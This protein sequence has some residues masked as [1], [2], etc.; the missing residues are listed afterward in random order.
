MDSKF[1]SSFIPK[2]SYG[3]AGDEKQEFNFFSVV[4]I[5]LFILSIFVTGGLFFYRMSLKSDNENLK[6]Q[7]ST[8]AAAIDI[9][10]IN[11][12]MAFEK[13]I[14]SIKEI[15]QNHVA[16]SEYFNLLEKNTVSKVQFTDLKYSSLRGRNVEVQMSGKASTFGAIA[17]QEDVFLQ[18]PNTRSVS[19]NNMRSDKKTG[20][21]AFAF[22]GE[23]KMDLIKFKLPEEFVA[24]SIEETGEGGEV[25][26]LSLPNLDD[27]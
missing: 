22:K 4:A 11:E 15:L 20:S 24:A 3:E 18:D 10:G 7:L 8:A 2:A 17:L 26:D 21:V 25:E 5:L 14:A 1:S 23:F 12:I 27:I 19:F 16:V 13:R 9:K 6:S